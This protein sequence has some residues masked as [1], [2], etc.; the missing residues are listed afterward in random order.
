M[1]H[2]A[3]ISLCIETFKS[4]QDKHKTFELKSMSAVWDP[5]RQIDIINIEK[6]QRRAAWFV[7]NKYQSQASVNEITVEILRTM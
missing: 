2:N 7:F 3:G 1:K 6:V 5:Y 4:D